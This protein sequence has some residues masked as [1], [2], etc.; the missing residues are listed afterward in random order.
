MNEQKTNFD[1]ETSRDDSDV[2]LDVRNLDVYLNTYSGRIHAVRD[3]S[4]TLKKGETLVVVGESGCG[5]SMTARAI[6]QLLPEKISE[7]GEQSQILFNGTDILKMPEK[8]KETE[9]R[10]KYIS[11]IFQDPTTF[12]NPT[13]TVGEQIAESLLLHSKMKKKEAMEQALSLLKMV[14]ITNPEKRIRQ[15]PH[16][17]SGG[18]RQRVMI[19]MALACEPKILIADEPTTALDVTIQAQVLETMKELRE[20]FGSAMIMITHDL[21]IIAEVCDEVSVVYAGQIVEHGTLEDVFERTLHPYTEGL[22]GSLP[23]IEERRHRLQPIPGLMPDPTDLPKGCCF[24]PRCKYCT[25]ACTKARPEMKWVS[26]THY[27][28]CSRYDEP[29]F[30]IERSVQ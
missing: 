29:G 8:K 9:L 5:K 16:E 25:E 30:K 28:R 12:L 20:K 24:A 27:V 3:V 6:M 14:K 18:M 23:N 26:D 7:V 13:M 19:A 2:I 10:G 22:F 11:M 21:G 1:T 4:F 17:L 15:Y